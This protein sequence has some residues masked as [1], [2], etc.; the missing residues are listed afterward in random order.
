MTKKRRSGGRK[1]SDAGRKELVHCANCG[2]L[3]PRDKAIKVTKSAFPLDGTLARELR[4][5]GT[6]LPRQKI[7]KY[8]CVSCAIHAGII[9]IRARD[10]R[11]SRRRR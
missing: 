4:E 9:R 5:S 1:G 3:I 7:V 8:Y 6:I 10:Q 11:R 2:A